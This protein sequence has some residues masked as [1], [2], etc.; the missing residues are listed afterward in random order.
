MN[1]LGTGGDTNNFFSKGT[2]LR[3]DTLAWPRRC[4]RRVM[5]SSSP[6]PPSPIHRKSPK[7]SGRGN[8]NA[9][10]VGCGLDVLNTL[11][12]R[13]YVMP[14][15]LR[16][17]DNGDE[18]S[19]IWGIRR[20]GEMS[21]EHLYVF[22]GRCSLRDGGWLA[23]QPGFLCSFLCVPLRQGPDGALGHPCTSRG[24]ALA[25]RTSQ[26]H[27]ILSK[28]R[29]QDVTSHSKGTGTSGTLTRQDDNIPGPRF[30][31]A[32]H[33]CRLPIALDE[34]ASR[35]GLLRD[36]TSKHVPN[37]SRDGS[38]NH[39]LQP[40]GIGDYTRGHLSTGQPSG[41]ASCPPY[42]P[43]SH[44]GAL[45]LLHTSPH[46]ASSVCLCLLQVTTAGHGWPQPVSPAGRAVAPGM[47]QPS[48]GHAARPHRTAEAGD[49][50]DV[51]PWL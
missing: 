24:R 29:L 19:M 49:R 26:G 39:R 21:L 30:G 13:L 34:L 46:E 15:R 31:H 51:L 33:A 48:R 32:T 37:S 7:L 5:G 12:T 35:R 4:C 14:S 47:A 22:R 20:V 9:C 6:P 17:L 1:S 43:P 41:E 50:R 8:S 40:P 11:S 2:H 28:P 16:M 10:S 27:S 44:S 25:G 45:I 38:P 3:Q 36:Y 23:R 18:M 42:H